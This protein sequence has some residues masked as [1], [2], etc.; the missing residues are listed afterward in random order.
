[1][2]LSARAHSL[3]VR[4]ALVSVGALYDR[5]TKELETTLVGI[6][7]NHLVSILLMVNRK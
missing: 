7:A 2:P 4:C 5:F 6:M 1:M 3:Y